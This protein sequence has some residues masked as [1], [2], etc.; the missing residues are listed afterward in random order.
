M[1]K[2]LFAYCK[3]CENTTFYIEKEVEGKSE[4]SILIQETLCHDGYGYDLNTFN[5]I[6]RKCKSV[7]NDVFD[8]MKEGSSK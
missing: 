8:F 7:N 5:I 6:C 1:K 3:K 4:E 2:K